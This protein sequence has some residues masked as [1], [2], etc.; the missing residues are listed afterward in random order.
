MFWIVY[1]PVGVFSVFVIFGIIMAIIQEDGSIISG[2]LL[3]GFI[4]GLAVCIIGMFISVGT[5]SLVQATEI[6][7]TEN[8]VYLVSLSSTDEVSGNISGS[9]FLIAGAMQGSVSQEEVYKY[10]YYLPGTNKIASDSI[11]SNN[12]LLVEDSP[13]LP[14]YIAI[15][16]ECPEFD[17]FWTI[18]SCVGKGQYEKEF[19]IPPN[20]VLHI[21]S[22]Q[23]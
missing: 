2:A 7:D 18:H 21:I 14:Y 15:S 8:P 3:S 6:Y 10:R 11:R 1:L 23:P 20:S 4:I 5:S 22:V 9:Y 16:Y 17:D 12:A 13:G 19:H